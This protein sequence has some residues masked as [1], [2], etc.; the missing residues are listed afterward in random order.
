MHGF[1]EQQMQMASEM[2]KQAPLPYSWN[3][4][5]ILGRKALITN[6]SSEWFVPRVPDPLYI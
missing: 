4:R 2:Q 1:V 5:N 3:S 6:E